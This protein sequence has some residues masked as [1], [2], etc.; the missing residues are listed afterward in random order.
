[1]YDVS[2]NNAEKNVLSNGTVF[3]VG[4][5]GEPFSIRLQNNSNNRCMFNLFV[6]GKDA[7]N[8][9]SGISYDATGFVVE[10]NKSWDIQGWRR[11]DNASAQFYFAK[12]GDTYVD[13]VGADTNNLGIITVYAWT[14]KPQVFHAG[15]PPIK[16][17]YPE[18]MRGA[19]PSMG[20]G[21]SPSMGTG[22]GMEQNDPVNKTSF[23]KASYSPAKII[24]LKYGT[25]EDYNNLVA[26]LGTQKDQYGAPPGWS[27]KNYYAPSTIATAPVTNS[28]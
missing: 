23:I 3:F 9:N 11:G 17:M 16:P 18:G 22:Y 21:V 14:E 8:P 20:R 26:S 5:L 27:T 19:F 12:R 1:M 28:N 24:I 6:D 13:R 15:F 25:L 2:L 10:A 7:G 4:Q